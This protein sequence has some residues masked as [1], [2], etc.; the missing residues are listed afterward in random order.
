MAAPEDLHVSFHLSSK[1]I[2]ATAL[3]PDADALLL[4]KQLPQD[5]PGLGWMPLCQP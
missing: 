5:L 2:S 4:G 3:M 1:A